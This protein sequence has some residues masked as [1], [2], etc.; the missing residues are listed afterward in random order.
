MYIESYKKSAHRQFNQPGAHTRKA[1]VIGLYDNLN[2]VQNSDEVIF[3][4]TFVT[5]VLPNGH[6][7][8]VK[9]SSLTYKND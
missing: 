3:E 9:K 1:S 6:T 8:K 2:I 7:I 4:D 5:G